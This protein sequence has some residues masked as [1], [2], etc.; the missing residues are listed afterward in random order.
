MFFR[1]HVIKYTKVLWRFLFLNAAGEKE[2]PILIYIMIVLYNM[3]HIVSHN[4]IVIIP[5]SRVH[6]HML[7]RDLKTDSNSL[8]QNRHYTDLC[9]NK[10]T[11]INCVNFFQF[12]CE[13]S[14]CQYFGEFIIKIK[15]NILTFVSQVL[16]LSCTNCSD[17]LN[18]CNTRIWC[19]YLLANL[20]CVPLHWMEYKPVFFIPL[21]SYVAIESTDSF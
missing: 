8:S 7:C 4:Q 19:F 11:N 12:T 13:N 3:F 5:S 10:F 20:I 18:L 2:P 17:F 14:S 9:L 16:F 1:F 15:H 21:R 6:I